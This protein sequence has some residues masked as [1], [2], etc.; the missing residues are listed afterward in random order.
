[1]ETQANIQAKRKFSTKRQPTEAQ[2]AAMKAK[3]DE[4]IFTQ[5][6]DT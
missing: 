5:K 6:M 1:M 4:L 2:K 3:R